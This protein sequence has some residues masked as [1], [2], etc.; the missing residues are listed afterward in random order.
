MALCTAPGVQET[1]PSSLQRESWR[2]TS[3]LHDTQCLWEPL[4]GGRRKW[5]PD[6]RISERSLN[7]LS[8]ATLHRLSRVLSQEAFN[9]GAVI[10][11][12]QVRK[13]MPGEGSSSE[14]LGWGVA[15]G[16]QVCPSWMSGLLAQA[17]EWQGK[18][19][20]PRLRHSS[21]APLWKEPEPPGQGS[22]LLTAGQS[23]AGE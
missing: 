3:A 17:Q 9:R 10:C 15:I 23:S 19:T 1:V 2:R 18:V 11:I 13:E 4:G 5:R 22:G 20:S 6:Q 8:Q 21:S 16:T 12:F 7:C 14:V